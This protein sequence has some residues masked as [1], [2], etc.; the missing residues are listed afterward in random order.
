M[1]ISDRVEF[2]WKW[3]LLPDPLD[4]HLPK[5]SANAI[6]MPASRK[7]KDR[8]NAKRSDKEKPRKEDVFAEGYTW[9]EFNLH[10][11]DRNPSQVKVDLE[12]D[13]QVW[14]YLGKTSTDAKDQYT[15]DPS[16]PRHNVKGNYLDT[17]PKPPKPPKPPRAPRP[18]ASQATKRP[19]Y[20]AT[21]S[22]TYPYPSA[23]MFGTQAG[24]AHKPQQAVAPSFSPSTI[25]PQATSQSFNHSYPYGTA[26]SMHRPNQPFSTQ[27]FEVK[28]PQIQPGY[29]APRYQASN[30]PHQQTCKAVGHTP[31]QGG[32]Q[33][34]SPTP[35][36]TAASP[37]PAPANSRQPS[38]YTWQVHPSIY[39]KYPFF[40][41]HHNR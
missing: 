1:T 35:R 23:N 29:A 15:E 7:A 17:L 2:E 24:Q 34:Q 5:A 21:S 39:Q 26:A 37:S 25:A 33:M 4:Y 11:V 10:E 22:P 31:Q 14:H 13:D 16:K 30:P 28:Q 27:R 40:Q 38:K 8:L 41:V 3:L 12:K 18:A 9:A 6:P 19:S 20:P 32:Q 36:P